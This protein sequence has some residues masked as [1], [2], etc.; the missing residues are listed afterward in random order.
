MKMLKTTLGIIAL[1]AALAVPLHAQTFLHQGLVAYYPFNGGANDASGFQNN[2]FTNT[3]TFTADRFGVTNAAVAFD[4]TEQISYTNAP[5]IE[6]I[7]NLT[8]SCWIQYT[9]GFSGFHGL[10]CKGETDMFWNGFQIGVSRSHLQ[11]QVDQANFT[12]SA[13]INDGNWHAISVTFDNSNAVVNLYIDGQLDSSFSTPVAV[14]GVTSPLN[15]GVDRFGTSFYIGTL[16]EVRLFNRVLTPIE[17]SQLYAVESAQFALPYYNLA[18][19]LNASVQSSNTVVGTVSNTPAPTVQSLA[20][21]NLLS[22]LAN[23]AHVEGSWP[24]NSF[25]KNTLLALAGESF[26]V[27][28]GTNLL[29]NVSDKLVSNAGNPKITAGKFST[30][31]GLVVPKTKAQSIQIGGITFDDTFEP[32]DYNLKFYLDGVL[33]R[34]TT[35]TV[36]VS[37]AYSETRTLSL[38]TA[39]GDGYAQGV[40]FVCTGT[41]SATVTVPLHL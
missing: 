32:A 26:V 25:P 35:D 27:L 33:T 10:I 12:S 8:V 36:P 23:D 3:A 19:A 38:S 1:A 28:N 14:L 30:V 41:V 29:L 24:S 11:V 17:I 16:D 40:P 13:R 15:L 18:F 7:T 31:N 37:G 34:T 22:V 20:T 21:K 39:A 4:G 9:N 2:P 5:Q 6:A